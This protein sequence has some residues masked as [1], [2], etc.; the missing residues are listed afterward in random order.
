MLGVTFYKGELLGNLVTPRMS[1][2]NLLPWV[3]PTKKEGIFSSV[4][5]MMRE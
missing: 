4:G 2:W 5:E 1:L 3:L